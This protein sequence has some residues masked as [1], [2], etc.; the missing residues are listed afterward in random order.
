MLRLGVGVSRLFLLFALIALIAP[1]TANARRD[2]GGDEQS[3]RLDDEI[4]DLGERQIAPNRIQLAQIVARPPLN[5][6]VLAN[7]FNHVRR[8]HPAR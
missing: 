2:R 7:Q 3:E 6:R 4:G 8:V 1:P 5:G